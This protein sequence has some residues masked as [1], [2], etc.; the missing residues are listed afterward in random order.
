M[1]KIYSA[2]IVNSFKHV[3]GYNM[4]FVIN[5]R[6]DILRWK[7]KSLKMLYHHAVNVVAASSF[8]HDKQEKLYIRLLSK[9]K[10]SCLLV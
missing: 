3:V 1:L 7:D 6:A 5:R 2:I 4:G 10:F 9:Q 8:L